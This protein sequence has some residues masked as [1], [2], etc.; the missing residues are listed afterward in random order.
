MVSRAGKNV[1]VSIG[2]ILIIFGMF[3]FF[4]EE[5][6]FV[7]LYHPYREYGFPLGVIG[8]LVLLFGIVIPVQS[9][10]LKVQ[11]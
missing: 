1:I 11:T 4:F 3:A 7:E 5:W 2:I 9:P 8:L 10:K 6:E